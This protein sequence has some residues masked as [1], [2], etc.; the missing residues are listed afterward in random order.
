MLPTPR[1]GRY[2]RTWG[3][4]PSR[5]R[6]N[7][8]AVLYGPAAPVYD[9][10]TRWLFLGEW[11]RWQRTA[12]PLLPETGLVVEMG[13]GTADLARRGARPSRPWL[14]VEPSPSMLRA[15]R[16]RRFPPETGLVRAEAGALPLPDGTAAAV[17]ATFP[18][19]FILAPSTADEVRRVLRPGGVLVVV[20]DGRL[21]PDGIRRRV[22]RVA[23]S[24]FYGRDAAP[25]ATG[26][27]VFAGLEGMLRL[28]PT[29]HG[30]AAVFTAVREADESARTPVP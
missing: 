6:Q 11:E 23:L 1:G 14:A 5:L 3:A 27:A 2:P 21:R 26:S 4:R 30:E 19:P 12:L 28:I 17:V 8:F 7:A 18:G 9:A 25:S 15:A 20:L 22:R 13:A 29:R 16:R 24:L 10:F